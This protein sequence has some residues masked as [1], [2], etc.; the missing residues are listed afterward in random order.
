MSSPAYPTA[1]TTLKAGL[2]LSAICQAC[3]HGAEID[4][5]ALIASGRGDVPLLDLRF[6]CARCGS[7]DCQAVVSGA[8]LSQ[9]W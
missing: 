3:Q 9:K 4:L 2:S 1:R 7:R 6:R 5:A 8:K